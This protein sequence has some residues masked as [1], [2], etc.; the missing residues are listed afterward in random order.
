MG[1]AKWESS[2]VNRDSAGGVEGWVG[3][4]VLFVVLKI[5]KI[6]FI[7]KPNANSAD[8]NR[9]QIQPQTLEPT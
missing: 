5:L 2:E 1:G 8:Y 3:V 9:N 6:L 7:I 4:A